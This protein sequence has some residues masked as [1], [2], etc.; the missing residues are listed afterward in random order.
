MWR[1]SITKGKSKQFAILCIN[2]LVQGATLLAKASFLKQCLPISAYCKYH[3][4]WFALS[5]ALQNGILHILEPLILYRRYQQQVTWDYTELRKR[6][7]EIRGNLKAVRGAFSLSEK[8]LQIV[9]D[10][11]KFNDSQERRGW[12]YL[13][14]SFKHCGMR[15]TARFFLRKI[16]A[17]SR[18][19]AKRVKKV[20]KAALGS[21]P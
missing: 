9:Q 20:A 3:D 21:K 1:D 16:L 14:Y 13:A 19:V 11:A 18:R 4:W 5:A 7:E 8:S 2:N 12:G 6:M 15:R 17:R 10:A